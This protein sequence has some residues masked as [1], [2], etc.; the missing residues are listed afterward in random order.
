MA[1]DFD[2][3]YYLMD[4]D[5]ASNHPVLTW[6][7]TNHRPFIFPKPIDNDEIVW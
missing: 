6:G 7:A 5:G 3:E 2:N 1:N 4:V